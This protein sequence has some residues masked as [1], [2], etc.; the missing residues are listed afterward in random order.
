MSFDEK[1]IVQ[2]KGSS[3]SSDV[4]DIDNDPNHLHDPRAED[5]LQRGLKARQISMI[6]VSPKYCIFSLS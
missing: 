5:T 2:E 4:V 6:A 3:V 1:Q